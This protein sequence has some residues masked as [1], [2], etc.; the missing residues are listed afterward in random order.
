LGANFI[1]LAPDEEVTRIT[2]AAV[3]FAGPVGL[4]VPVIAD[5]SV[6]RLRDAVC[7]A[8]ETDYHLAHVDP[9][10]DFKVKEVADIRQAR[11][12]ERCPRCEKGHLEEFRGIEVG[13][14]FKLGTKY[15]E[16]LRATYLDEK[17]QERLIVM[18]CYGIGVGRTVAAAIEQC[19][20]ADGI[21]FPE[22]IAPFQVEILPV[23][24]KNPSVVQF[25]EQLYETLLKEG[26]EVLL[27]DRD[28]RPG[29]KFKDADLIGI[30]WRVVVGRKL[31]DEGLV[32]IKSRETGEVESVPAPEAAKIL[33]ER[34]RRD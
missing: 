6:M 16:A 14:V 22:Q 17:G 13:H 3:G 15:S 21:I 9:G 1:V 26:R 23:Q 25:A 11:V 7:G 32:E 28:I 33:G 20:D 2:K 30:P 24:T 34:M 18:G 29:V 27:D 5:P 19:H 31:D 12:G 10:R 4:S 8:N